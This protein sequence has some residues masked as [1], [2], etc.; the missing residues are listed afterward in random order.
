MLISLP[1]GCHQ[2]QAGGA[3]VFTFSGGVLN[4]LE[5]GAIA[6]VYPTAP[7]STS[8]PSATGVG[9]ILVSP[10]PE[11]IRDPTLYHLEAY[12]GD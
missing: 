7:L 11:L 12:P 3:G 9:F 4:S 2:N 5:R 6:Y 10:L 1:Y 8:F